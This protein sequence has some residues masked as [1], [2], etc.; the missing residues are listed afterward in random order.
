MNAKNL[1]LTGFVLFILSFALPAITTT[2][3]MRLMHLYG[4]YCA[5]WTA[6]SSYVFVVDLRHGF[7]EAAFLEMVSGWISP[8]VIAGIVIRSTRFKQVLAVVVP[9]LMIAPWMIFSADG[10]QEARPLLG[11]YV[12]MLGCILVFAPEYAGW[13]RKLKRN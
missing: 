11:H 5:M 12:W 10:G 6:F 7:V 3:G 2:A 1:G 9:L 8:L 13:L 4:W